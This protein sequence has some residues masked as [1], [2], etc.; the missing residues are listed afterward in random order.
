MKS[1]YKVRI[2][3]DIINCEAFIAIKKGVSF[4]DFVETVYNRMPNLRVSPIIMYC[5]DRG[6]KIII[7]TESDFSLLEEL[8]SKTIFIMKDVPESALSFA[9]Q[10]E[11]FKN[12]VEETSDSD[13]DTDS[14]CDTISDDEV[15]KEDFANIQEKSPEYTDSDFINMP[16]KDV[17]SISGVSD[18][19][20]SK[21]CETNK[22]LSSDAWNPFSNEVKNDT[23]VMNDTTVVNEPKKDLCSIIKEMEYSDLI[24]RLEIGAERYLQWKRAQSYSY[25]AAFSSLPKPDP[26]GD[27]TKVSYLDQLYPLGRQ[28]DGIRTMK[29]VRFDDHS[30]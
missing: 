19:E 6:D 20:T 3:S 27:N 12:V 11:P 18:T 17:P 28:C 9:I 16:Q 15:N 1:F 25:V 24:D 21:E 22:G 29:K 14:L 5:K 10:I 7:Q 26:T 30:K 13:D 23:R 2:P 4:A 8:Y